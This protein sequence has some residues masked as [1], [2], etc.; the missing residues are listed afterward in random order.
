LQ[1]LWR[2]YAAVVGRIIIVAVST[3]DRGS[4]AIIAGGIVTWP[5]VS[6]RGG[7]TDGSGTDSG[8][9]D[10]DRNSRAYTTVNATTLDATTIDTAAVDTSAICE[11]VSGNSPNE[12]DADDCGCS[13]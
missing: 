7:G 2:G 1:R 12:P 5:V 11:G 13:K 4:S 6:T 10:A 8:G 9:T 3:G